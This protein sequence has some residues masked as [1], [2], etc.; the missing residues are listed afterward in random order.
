MQGVTFCDDLNQAVFVSY[1]VFVL[2]GVFVY[3]CICIFSFQ[4][5]GNFIFDFLVSLPFQN[6]GLG[7]RC[8]LTC[9]ARGGRVIKYQFQN[10]KN[11]HP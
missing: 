2:Y 1:G 5:L 11:G 6:V 7:A 10:F 3:L 4:T 8:N 9:K